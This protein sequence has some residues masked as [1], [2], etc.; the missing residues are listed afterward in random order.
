MAEELKQ[1]AETVNLQQQQI[2]SL[3]DA[4]KAMPG[5]ANPMAVNVHTAPPDAVAVRADKVQRLALCMRKSNRIK[6][7][8]FDSDIQIFIKRFGEEL[9]SLKQINGIDF[10][11]T[12]DE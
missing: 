11:L 8:R 1:M 10:V 5:I 12:R 3:I 7:F 9:T 4:I 6:P 2:A